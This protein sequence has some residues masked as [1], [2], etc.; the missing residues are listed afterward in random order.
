MARS[1]KE[2]FCNVAYDYEAKVRAITE[3][4]YPRERR[5]T[6]P[7]TH[8]EVVIGSE[9]LMWGPESLFQP[10]TSHMID[11]FTEFEGLHRSISDSALKCDPD[12]R[13]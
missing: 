4:K 5:Y 13:L 8:R 12:I 1:I 3:G 11:S 9:D 2:S 7:G 10:I 6:L